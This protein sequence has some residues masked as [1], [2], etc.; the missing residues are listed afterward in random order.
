MD[1]V[2][3][4]F[5][6]AVRETR[7]YMKSV[8]IAGRGVEK[9]KKLEHIRIKTYDRVL[10]REIKRYA[11]AV[12]V[13]ALHPFQRAIVDISPGVDRLRRALGQAKAIMNVLASIRDQALY[14]VAMARGRKDLIRVRRSY[15]GRVHDVLERSRTVFET[16]IE[17][18]RALSSIKGVKMGVPTV[19]LAG[20]P[21]VGKS[22]LLY[23]LTGSRPEIAPY[24]FTTKNLR[25]GFFTYNHVK[26]QVIDT[27]GLLDRPPERMNPVERRALSAIRHLADAMVFVYDPLQEIAPQ[28]ALLTTLKEMLEVP[29]IVVVNKTD[30]A[31]A[32]VEGL[33]VSA[34]TGAGIEELKLR[35]FETLGVK[36]WKS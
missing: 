18:K 17:A 6:K 34:L 12:D 8:N 4:I 13:D 2:E 26:Y 1:P 9:L 19:V 21:N 16:I 28:T 35:I 14:D 36:A 23:A 10:A 20:F 27:P 30:V 11:R 15:L 3:L 29:V 24:P 5:G 22:S 33:R 32:P 7:K 31:D 25:V